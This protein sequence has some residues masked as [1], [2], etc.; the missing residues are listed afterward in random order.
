M[1][2]R[3]PTRKLKAASPKGRGQTVWDAR[4]FIKRFSR[5]PEDKW[6]RG[7]WTDDNGHHCAEGHL[8]MRA[9]GKVPL[10]AFALW[11]LFNDNRLGNPPYFNDTV[12]QERGISPKEAILEALRGIPAHARVHL[13][14][15][16]L[17]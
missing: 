14:D 1:T 16:V 6:C 12:S 4:Y 3:K 5:I 9:G 17:P 8:G 11:R 10:V 2:K 13:E 7:W 15:L